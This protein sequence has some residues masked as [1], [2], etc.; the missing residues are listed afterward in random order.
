MCEHGSAAFMGA[1]ATHISKMQ[2]WA[3]RV[4][5]LYFDL[6]VPLVLLDVCVNYWIFVDVSHCNFYVQLL[7]LLL[8]T[9]M[10]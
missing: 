5:F 1:A 7:P 2:M 6:A 9:H 8:P 10:D 4:Y 3:E